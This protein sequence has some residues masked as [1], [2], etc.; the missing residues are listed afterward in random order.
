LIALGTPFIKE[1]IG[2]MKSLLVIPGSPFAYPPLMTSSMGEGK[3]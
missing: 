2:V 3:F 1:M